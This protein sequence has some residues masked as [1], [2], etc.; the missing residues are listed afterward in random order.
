MFGFCRV[1]DKEKLIRRWTERAQ[2]YEREV[3]TADL[4]DYKIRDTYRVI[5]DNIRICAE[6]L[7]AL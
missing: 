7:K 1:T 6:E 2:W 5:A 4:Q 3:I